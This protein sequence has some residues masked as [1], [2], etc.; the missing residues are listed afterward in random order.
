MIG[1]KDIVIPAV[2][3]P[4]SLDACARVVQRQWPHARF[5]NAE[6]GEKYSKYGDIP[7]GTIRHLLA[8]PNEAAEALW[9]ADS[10][11]SPVNSMLYLIL[12]EQSVTAVLDDPTAGEMPGILEGIKT[13]MEMEIL[14]TAAV[15]DPEAA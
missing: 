10:P 15:C 13:M 7:F 11:D 4:A 14:N 12:S 8:Y 6:T 9:D 2:G 1:G 3:S 5:E